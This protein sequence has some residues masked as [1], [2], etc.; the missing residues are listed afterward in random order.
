MPPPD[1]VQAGLAQTDAT[2]DIAL[3]GRSAIEALIF[4]TVTQMLME[5]ERSFP[6]AITSQTLL[7]GDLG[8]DSLDM[9]MLI[10]SVNQHLQLTDIPFEKLLIANGRPVADLSLQTLTDFLW[11][12]LRTS[13]VSGAVVSPSV[14]QPG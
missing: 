5:M 12:L 1:P 3:C 4:S 11:S 6:G 9:A 7:V 2:A 10:A 13:P 8:C 14:V